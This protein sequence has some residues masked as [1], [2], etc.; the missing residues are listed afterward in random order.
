MNNPPIYYTIGQVRF[1]PVLA[2]GEFIGSLQSALRAAFPDFFEDTRKEFEINM[3]TD[4]AK[5]PEFKTL[6]APRWHFRNEKQSSGYILMLDSIIFHTT[7]Y[8]NSGWFISSLMHGLEEVNKRVG[9]SFIEGVGIRTLDLIRP[10]T[11]QGLEELVDTRLLGIKS[12]LQ[13]AVKHSISELVLDGPHGQLTSRLVQLN[14]KLGIPVDLSPLTLLL[15][16]KLQGFEGFHAI[17]ENDCSQQKRFSYD[18]AEVRSRLEQVKEGVTTP[19]YVATTDH[20]RKV[21]W[22]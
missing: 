20:A 19:F 15:P 22:A 2:M 4:G 7:A 21:F 9:L 5:N 16:E 1:S 11:E 6:T 12:S 18:E 14:G 3:P 17:L 10:E 8:Q 13:G